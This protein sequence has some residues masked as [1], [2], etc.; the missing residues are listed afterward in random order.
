MQDFERVYINSSPDVDLFILD[1]KLGFIDRGRL[2][3]VAVGL[4]T[5][6]QTVI[7][8][9]DGDMTHINERLDPAERQPGV[10]HDPSEDT[11]L[12]RRVLAGKYFFL[13]CLLDN[14][15]EHF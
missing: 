8:V 12:C 3:P 1:I 9:V 14:V 5:M 15:V 2:T 10:I 11:L 7:P 13:P 6:F 4:E